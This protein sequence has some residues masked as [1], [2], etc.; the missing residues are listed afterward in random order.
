MMDQGI[1][2]EPPPDMQPDELL[3]AA[4]RAARLADAGPP[5]LAAPLAFGAPSS[6]PI[7]AAAVD[8]LVASEVSSR[9]FYERR[10]VHPIWPQGRSGIT[11]GIGYDVG[12]VSAGTLKADWMGS[13]G[14][15]HWRNW[16]RPAA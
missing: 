4:T 10:L 2:S 12:T 8:L 6:T 5:L 3:I 11:I 1:S 9:A 15:A 13:W 7:S 16:P 14:T